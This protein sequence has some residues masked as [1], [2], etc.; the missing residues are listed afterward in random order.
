MMNHRELLIPA[1]TRIVLRYIAYPIGGVAAV[2]AEDPDIALVV[3]V[4]VGMATEG[5][6]AR[7]FIKRGDPKA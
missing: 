7:D 3:T 1:L 6:Y 5:W 4:L 2:L